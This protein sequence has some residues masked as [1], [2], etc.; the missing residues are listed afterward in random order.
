MVRNPLKANSC[1][2]SQELLC[3]LRNLKVHLRNGNNG[4]FLIQLVI[5][6][7]CVTYNSEP[8]LPS[9]ILFEFPTRIRKGVVFLT[10]NFISVEDNVRKERE[11]KLPSLYFPCCHD[12]TDESAHRFSPF[13][14]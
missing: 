12:N 5:L 7:I 1:S 8:L 13:F 11:Q 2:A 6:E 9:I 10:T 3:F 4:L 14:K